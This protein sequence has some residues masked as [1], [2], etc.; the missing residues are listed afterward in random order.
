MNRIDGRLLLSPSDLVGGLTC[1]E[2][3]RNC[4]DQRPRK[5][6]VKSVTK[7]SANACTESRTERNCELR[8]EKSEVSALADPTDT[9]WPFLLTLRRPFTPGGLAFRP[10]KPLQY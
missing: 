7:V 10:A 1:C 2:G 4:Q 3:A 9:S 6:S 8:Q 5:L